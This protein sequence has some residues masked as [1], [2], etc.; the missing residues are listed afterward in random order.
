MSTLDVF[1][2]LQTS[3]LGR[4]IGGLNHLFCAAIEL[5]H[6]VGMI[7]LLSS[8]LLVSLRLLGV[9]LNHQPLIRLYRA[10]TGFI[11]TGLALLVISGLLIFI[12]AATSYYPNAF[13][14][15][16]FVLLGLALL[17]HLTAYRKILQTPSP[18]VLAAKAT[19]VLSLSLWF[20]VAF[21][22]RFIGFF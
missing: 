16:K 8:V 4:A 13:F 15:N 2:A 10:T 12:P 1:K 11:W 19:A 18:N 20:G 6:I 22:G 9:G 3:Q 21:A 5:A 14:W 7:L 17:F